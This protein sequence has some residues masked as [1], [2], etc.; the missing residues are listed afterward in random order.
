VVPGAAG[1]LT[2][3][4]YLSPVFL[5]R[6]HSTACIRVFL[7]SHTLFL[8][9]REMEWFNNPYRS[10]PFCEQICPLSINGT[11]LRGAESLRSRSVG[12]EMELGR[13][14]PAVPILCHMNRLYPISLRSILILSHPFMSRAPMWSFPFRLSNQNCVRATCPAYVVLRDLIILISDEEH[15]TWSSSFGLFSVLL[16]LHPS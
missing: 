8:V 13:F 12:P 3:L 6:E 7:T 10:S 5:I 16:S 2:A 9:S 4:D 14:P 11:E 15:K 1:P